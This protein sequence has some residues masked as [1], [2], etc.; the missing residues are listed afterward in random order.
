MIRL[1]QISILCA[2]QLL[3]ASWNK[4]NKAAAINYFW[5]AK[6]SQENQTD[7]ATDKG[8]LFKAQRTTFANY[9][10]IIQILE[11]YQPRMLLT[12]IQML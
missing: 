4:V 6:T 8:D 7:V 9:E 3:E 12:L 5:K 2:L 10:N 11:N 1:D